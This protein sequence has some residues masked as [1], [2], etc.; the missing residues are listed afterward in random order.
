MSITK[1]ADLAGVSSST[2]SRVINNH[3]RVAPAT[4]EAVRRAM[5]RLDYTPS[6][7]RPGPKPFQRQRA[8]SAHVKFLALG[9]VRGSATP[10]FSE[11]LSGV[12]EAAT[13]HGLRL[14]VL[15]RP[16]RRPGW[17]ASFRRTSPWTACCCTVACPTPPPG[18]SSGGSPPSG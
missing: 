15:A 13:R 8:E 12:S 11:L 16:R 1:V 18:R 10:G 9:S 6:D 5:A 7:R 17:P 4:A 2:V 3:P 14:S